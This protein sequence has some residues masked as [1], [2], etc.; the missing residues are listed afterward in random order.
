MLIA[1]DLLLLATDDADGS[2]EANVQLDPALAGAVL[3][4]LVVA[5]RL[6]LLQD[7]KKPQVVVIDTTPLGDPIL[8]PALQILVD[9]A[10][11]EPVTAIG[12]IGRGLRESLYENLQQRGIVRREKTRFWGIIPITRWPA[13]DSS[14]EDELR[15]ALNSVLLEGQD[16]TA[17]VAAVIALLSAADLLKLA[18]DKSQLK[19][20]Q[21]RGQDIADGNWASDSVK[22]AIQNA[23]AAIAAA[24]MV[25]ATTVVMASSS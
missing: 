6:E 23:Q 4:E 11:M 19:V 8:D 10:P 16:P 9:K 25:S 14:H 18:V 12:R 22:K 3:M 17:R 15:L 24:V 7:G 1:E 21:D 5:R 20:A 13:E 2:A